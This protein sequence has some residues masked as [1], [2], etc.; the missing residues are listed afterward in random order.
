MIKSPST[1]QIDLSQIG[2]IT[3]RQIAVGDFDHIFRIFR[4]TALDDTEK[5]AKI[6][7]HQLISP[8]LGEEEVL[9]FP[10]RVVKQWA[11]KFASKDSSLSAHFRS[12]GDS[13]AMFLSAVGALQSECNEQMWRISSHTKASLDRINRMFLDT[14]GT[15]TLT[16]LSEVSKVWI[17][18]TQ[19]LAELLQPALRE[20]ERIAESFQKLWVESDRKY[21]SDLKIIKPYL[22]KYKW[23]VSPSMPAVAV[24]I[25]ADAVRKG[26]VSRK[27]FSDLFIDYFTRGN[28][29]NTEE[30]VANWEKGSIAS[31]RL[32][33]IRNCVQLLRVEPTSKLNACYA[34]LPALIAQIDGVMTDCLTAQGVDFR[35]SFRRSKTATMGR[36]VALRHAL[37]KTPYEDFYEP[38]RYL[39]LDILFQTAFMGQPLSTAFNFNRHKIMHGEFLNYG[40]KDYV[41]R[42]I[43]ILDFLAHL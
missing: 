11:T 43:L 3:V 29:A 38:A 16:H 41:V 8:E 2:E 4:E 32:R 42:C 10:S 19:R 1:F 14:V 27:E 40:R 15:G 25:I 6:L 5:V 36:E 18:Q 28:W 9:D 20:Y 12:E 13:I 26:P 23:L 33:V 39:L 7:C 34:V 30:M 22:K 31:S 17:E 35:S 37:P 21:R 24:D